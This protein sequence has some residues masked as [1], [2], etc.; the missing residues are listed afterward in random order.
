[1]GKSSDIKFLAEYMVN[2]LRISL[3]HQFG[4]VHGSRCGN[5]QKWFMQALPGEVVL[6]TEIHPDAGKFPFT[7]HHDFHDVKPEWKGNA[8]FVYSNALDHSYNATYAVQQWMSEVSL[9]GV[10]ILEHSFFSTEPFVSKHDIY[11]DSL[12][13]YQDLIRR[14]GAFDVLAVV[15]S[16]SRFRYYKGVYNINVHF[17]FA[18][19]AHDA[20]CRGLVQHCTSP[21][22]A[23]SA[24]GRAMLLKS[25]RICRTPS[26]RSREGTVISY[27]WL[28][29]L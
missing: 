8:D 25:C 13:G 27:D 23:W 14:S 6:G 7:V 4:L 10:L 9:G 2:I 26:N 22:P 24:A 15:P 5:E 17:I 3:K 11:G 28:N 16:P 19:H 29:F 18:Q 21:N 12:G 20:Y 1:L